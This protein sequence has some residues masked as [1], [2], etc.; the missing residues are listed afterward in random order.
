[1]DNINNI[2]KTR[3]WRTFSQ[4]VL[5]MRV[6]L[7]FTRGSLLRVSN[8]TLWDSCVPSYKQAK[9]QTIKHKQPGETLRKQTSPFL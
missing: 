8:P 2:N 6:L 5:Q 3:I 1:M 9:E 7:V 4:K